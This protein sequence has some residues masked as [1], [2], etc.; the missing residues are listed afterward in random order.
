MTVAQAV[1]SAL[2]IPAN[3]FAHTIDIGKKVTDE[4]TK[5]TSV[6][7]VGSVAYAMPLLEAFDFSTAKLKL[8]DKGAMELDEQ[9][10][11]CYEDPKHDWAFGA[12]VAA[13]KMQLRNRLVPQTVELKDGMSISLTMEDLIKESSGGKGNAEYMKLV[14]E[15]KLAFGAYMGTLGKSAEAIAMAVNLFSNKEAL[16]TQPQ[17]IKEKF[18]AYLE[19]FAASLEPADADRYSKVLTKVSEAADSKTVELADF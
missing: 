15:T 4:R 9:G 10:F 13:V 12:L 1:A 14:K 17:G 18:S 7:K 16:A 8:D 19:G 5:E 2:A 3:W 6:T 11:P